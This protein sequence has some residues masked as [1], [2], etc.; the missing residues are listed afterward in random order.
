[1]GYGKDS[2][3]LQ[4]STALCCTNTALCVL[5]LAVMIIIKKYNLVAIFTGRSTKFQGGFPDYANIMR[6]PA[7][8]LAVRRFVGI[9]IDSLIRLDL[10]V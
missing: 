8:L 4:C 1:V 10:L 2:N 5:R 3:L 6:D 9:S 7:I